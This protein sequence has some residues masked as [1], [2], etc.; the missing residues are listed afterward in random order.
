MTTRHVPGLLVEGAWIP[1]IRTYKGAGISLA[2]IMLDSGDRLFPEHYLSRFDMPLSRQNDLEAPITV[3]LALVA[4]DLRSWHLIFVEPSRDANIEAL[5]AKLETARLVTFGDSEAREI[6]GKIA[7]IDLQEANLLVREAPGL[8]VV[9]DDPR[10]RWSEQF[11]TANLDI[12]LMIIEPFPYGDE[13]VIRVNGDSPIQDTENV[14]A[15]CDEHPTYPTC[16]LV[17]WTDS[18]PKALPGDITL[19]YGEVPTDW[20]LLQGDPNWQ[21]HPKSTFPLRESPP[22][23]IVETQDGMRRI[24]KSSSS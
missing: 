19:N 5:I 17:S 24:R 4:K 8:V 14:V 10:Q 3:D 1:A 20:E 18:V 12:D 16:L 23:E 11:A 9:T 6:E 7:Q 22:F 21:L 2:R 15:T 13:F